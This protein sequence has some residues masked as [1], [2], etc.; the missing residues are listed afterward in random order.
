MAKTKTSLIL[1]TDTALR[2][3]SKTIG[4]V[5][6]NVCSDQ[7]VANTFAR[8]TEG[9]YDEAETKEVTSQQ[10]TIYDTSRA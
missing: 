5:V 7:A 10:R 1:K 9:L 4:D 3:Y 8:A 6:A 2:S